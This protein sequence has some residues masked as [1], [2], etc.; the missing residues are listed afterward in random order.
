[1][2]PSLP[3]ISPLEAP[4]TPEVATYLTELMPKNARVPPLLLFRTFARDLNLATA[5]HA[6][7][8]F[9]LRFQ[10]ESHSAIEPRDREIIINRVCARCQ[11]EYEWGVHIASFAKRVGLSDSQVAATVLGSSS[12]PAWNRRDGLLIRLVDALHERAH[13]PDDLWAEMAQEWSDHQLL[14]LLSLTGWY[15]MIAY[16]ANGARVP[17]ET[18]APRFPAQTGAG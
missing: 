1:M 17:L 6:L 14:Q 16:I 4:F 9:H 18:W 5:I 15:H 2:N 3:R 11:C 10:P 12:D 8:R 13:V 7:G